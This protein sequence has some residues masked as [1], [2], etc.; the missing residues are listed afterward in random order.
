[1]KFQIKLSLTLLLI[2]CAVLFSCNEDHT[3]T[4]DIHQ[5]ETLLKNKHGEVIDKANMEVMDSKNLRIISGIDYIENSK[6]RNG[7]FLAY[8]LD[9]RDHYPIIDHFKI[10]QN[11]QEY[12]FKIDFILLTTI[13]RDKQE[14]GPQSNSGFLKAKCIE[15]ECI[16]V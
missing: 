3:D 9:I 7:K 1:M 6:A 14:K 13:E 5:I 12:D 11:F 15:G 8:T 2:V 4:M 10:D 16:M